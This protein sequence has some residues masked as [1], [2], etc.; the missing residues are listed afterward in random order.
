MEELWAIKEGLAASCDCDMDKSAERM[1]EITS[2]QACAE[3]HIH[4]NK[5][6]YP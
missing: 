1:R 3:R 6:L 4:N 5:F 2:R